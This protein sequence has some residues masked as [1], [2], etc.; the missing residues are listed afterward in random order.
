MENNLGGSSTGASST[1]SLSP[2]LP[3]AS[4]SSDSC[5]SPMSHSPQDNMIPFGNSASNVNNNQLT[6]SPQRHDKHQSRSHSPT[7]ST[8]SSMSS[9]SSHLP[10]TPKRH[11][12]FGQQ[13]LDTT[14]THAS[15]NASGASPNPKTGN[16]DSN[17]GSNN[18]NDAGN[19][20][21]DDYSDEIKVYNEEGAAEEEQRNSDDLK[22]EKT[23]IIQKTIEVSLLLYFL[24]LLGNIMKYNSILRKI[25]IP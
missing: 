14:I 1:P 19:T 8:T 4:S 2:D 9:K 6:Q 5:P 13:Q 17:S 10:S 12:Q 18:N 22:E 23:E 16:E 25:I 7:N 3:A 21:S 15:V 24:I 11:D 20:S